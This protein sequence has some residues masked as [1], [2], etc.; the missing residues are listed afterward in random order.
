MKAFCDVEIDIVSEKWNPAKVLRLLSERPEG[1]ICDVLLDQN[2]FAGVGNIIKSEALFMSKVHPLSIVEK[3]PKRQLE[4]VA[5]AARE[6][7]LVFYRTAKKG[8]SLR[9]HL[10]IYGKRECPDYGERVTV[11]KTGNSKRISYFCPSFQRR[12]V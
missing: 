6:F 1:Q 9:S 2:V 4:A 12:Y 3:I 5:N 11:Q 10:T 8:E 7:S